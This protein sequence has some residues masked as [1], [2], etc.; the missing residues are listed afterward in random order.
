MVFFSSNQQRLIKI[1]VAI[2]VLFG[3]SGHYFFGLYSLFY[4]EWIGMFPISIHYILELLGK[5]D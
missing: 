4:A 2:F 3:M 1:F 5:I